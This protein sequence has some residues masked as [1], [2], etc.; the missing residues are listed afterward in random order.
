MT[1]ISTAQMNNNDKVTD[2]THMSSFKTVCIKLRAILDNKINY[3]IEFLDETLKFN[4]DEA[5]TKELYLI[6]PRI[7]HSGIYFLLQ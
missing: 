3:S 6:L 1:I 2:N 7:C 4:G 5:Y